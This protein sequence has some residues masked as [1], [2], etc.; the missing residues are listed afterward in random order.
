[1]NSYS[2]ATYTYDQNGNQAS[3][4][5][6]DLY[7]GEVKQTLYTYDAANRLKTATGKVSDSIEYV[8]ENKYNGF[9]QRVQKRESTTNIIGKDGQ[10]EVSYTY[11]IYG[12]T[13]EHQRDSADPFYNEICYTAGVYDDTTGLYNL[14]ARYY[15]PADQTFLTQDTYRG[16][17]SGTAT[18]NYYAYC[19]GNP[20]SYTDPSGHVFRGIVSAA[21]GAYKVSKNK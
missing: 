21:M 13:T 12:E 4:T 18:L 20:V 16:S 15:S 17:R 10:A 2:N 8:Q 19:A 7:T 6:T 5:D 14:N 9:G 1:M 11:D 3:K